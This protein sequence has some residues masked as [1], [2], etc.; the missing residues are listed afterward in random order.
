MII[1]APGIATIFVIVCMTLG[2]LD[3]ARMVLRAAHLLIAC[4]R[5][6]RA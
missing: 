4:F 5:K 1:V 6:G 3:L 2:I